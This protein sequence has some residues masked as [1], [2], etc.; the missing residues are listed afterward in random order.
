MTQI[1]LASNALKAAVHAFQMQMVNLSAKDVIIQLIGLIKLMEHVTIRL[2]TLDNTS[3]AYNKN[4]KIVQIN[5]ELVQNNQEQLYACNA[6]QI[7][8]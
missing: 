7:T 8:L 6:N 4:A 3:I 2:A 1:Q 5:V